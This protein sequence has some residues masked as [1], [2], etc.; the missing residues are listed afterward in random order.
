MIVLDCSAAVAIV[1]ETL[2][3]NALRALMLENETTLTSEMFVAEVRNSFWKYVRAQLMTIEEAELYIE[4]A[5]GLVDEFVPLKENA[6][7][8]FAEAVRQNHSVYDMFYLT[9]VRRSAG[10]LFSLDKKLVNLCTEMK[11]DCVKEVAL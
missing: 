4:K 11:L 6:D 7:E 2:E 3:G 10:T 1:R 9:L 5:I 8:A